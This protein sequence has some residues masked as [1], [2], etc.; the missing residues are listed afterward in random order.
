MAIHHT[1][2]E[3]S[4]RTLFRI[5]ILVAIF[6]V[7]SVTASAQPATRTSYA[8]PK[9]AAPTITLST[10]PTPPVSGDNDFA[11]TVKDA[12]GKPVTGADVSVL[13][14]MAAMPS[15][16]MAE[17]KNTIALKAVSEKPAD[18]GKYSAKGQ[19]PMAGKWNV[20]VSIKVAG[21]D[22]AEKKLTLTAK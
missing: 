22:Y 7:A 10:K 12:K 15:M 13:L 19:V 11:V 17:M 2:T 16:N 1:T 18:A 9:P 14:V 3:H 6:A 21:K 20:T 4:R 8:Q 5:G